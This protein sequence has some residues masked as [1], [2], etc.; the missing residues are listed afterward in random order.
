MEVDT[1][2]EVLYDF[3][4]TTKDGQ[5]VT[6]REGEKLLLLKKTNDD[7]WQVIRCTGRPF[8]VPSSYVRVLDGKDVVLCLRD[9]ASPASPPTNFTVSVNIKSPPPLASRTKVMVNC[10]ESSDD[11]LSERYGRIPPVVDI[12]KKG[13]SIAEANI[14]DDNMSSSLAELAKEIEFRPKHDRLKYAGS[15]KTR[16]ERKMPLRQF[17]G[18]TPDLTCDTEQE[19][20]NVNNHTKSVEDL[21]DLENN[22]HAVIHQVVPTPRPLGNNIRCLQEKL[23]RMPNFVKSVEDNNLKDSS[24]SVGSGGGGGSGGGRTSAET[25][26]ASSTES[27]DRTRVPPVA[28]PRRIRPT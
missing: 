9:G 18:S 13:D 21:V 6:I 23:G 14:L 24:D 7:W 28:K 5:Q 4:Y 2:V 16:F 27:L 15:F 25:L 22:V 20:N 8:Y 19:P 17:S 10:D 1:N 12:K 26:G 3:E 11:S